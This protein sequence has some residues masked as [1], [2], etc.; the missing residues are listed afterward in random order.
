M[1]TFFGKILGDDRSYYKCTT[2]GC[3]VRKHVERACND[4]RSVITTYEGKHNHEIPAARG[5]GNGRPSNNSAGM[6]IRPTPLPNN[7]NYPIQMS[8][9]RPPVIEAQGGYG[10]GVLQNSESFGY[11]SFGSSM[12]YENPPFPRAKDEPKDD[13]FLDSLLC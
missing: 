4:P 13:S 8:S 10:L 5:S 11:S 1:I 12:S 3:P 6:A 2:P 7:S 9:L